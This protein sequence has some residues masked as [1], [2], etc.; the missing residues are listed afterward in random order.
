MRA[1][2]KKFGLVGRTHAIP[3]KPWFIISIVYL[4]LFDKVVGKQLGY[5]KQ[6]WGGRC[7]SPVT[8]T[9]VHAGEGKGISWEETVPRCHNKWE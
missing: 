5:S 8:H 7:F 2:E 9:D 3:Q 1:W 6:H 4:L